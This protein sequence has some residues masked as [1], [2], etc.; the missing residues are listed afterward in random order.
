MAG[1][2][3]LID[4]LR[5]WRDDHR[6][7]MRWHTPGHKGKTPD[8]GDFLD[9]AF[10]LTEVG[11]FGSGG[12]ADPVRQSE[13]LTAEVFGVTRSRYSV[14]GAS[15]PV[16]AAILAAAPAGSEVA[17]DRN[18]HRA[19]LAALVMGGYRPRW[20][21]P[22]ARG[23]VA[24]P[25]SP[26]GSAAALS[27]EVGA[28]VVTMPTYDGLANPLAPLIAEAH[29]RGIPVVVDEAHGSHFFGRAGFPPSAIEQGADLVIHGSH[30]TEATLTQTGLL[31]SQGPRVAEAD[32]ERWWRLFT[33]TSPSYLLMAAL[34]RLQWD[35]R[36][37][38]TQAGWETLAERGRAL[39]DRLQSRGW[40]VLQHWW[41]DQGCAADPAKLTLWGRGPELARELS[42]A[43]VVERV[44]PEGVTLFLAPGQDPDA[45]ERAL[46]GIAPGPPPRESH[47]PIAPLDI[48][49]RD[50]YLQPGR[51]VPLASAVGQVSAR[52]VVP[53]PPGIP[54]VYP[55]ERFTADVVDWIRHWR[56][57]SFGTIEGLEP[58]RQT[59]EGD[60]WI[61]D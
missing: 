30:K 48:L 14:Q 31:H 53:Y 35:R 20:I 7:R 21:V 10:D 12:P 22:A 54:I 34:D 11:P 19:V 23:A 47:W 3:P 4:A 6:G 55:G 29:A 24:L 61:V 51:A 45:V 58:G 38:A 39:W 56:A 8:R 57:Q 2:T 33:T 60:V 42:S 43:G 37:P 27:A 44:F 41:E 46:A 36:Q 16:T 13:Q 15:L 17:V 49:P 18:A 40:T 25:V 50:A 28:V 32:L 52:P 9:W 59:G 26:D 1:Q 5:R